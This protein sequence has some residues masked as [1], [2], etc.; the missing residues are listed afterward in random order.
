MAIEQVSSL[1]KE[2]MLTECCTHSR[3]ILDLLYYLICLNNPS[4]CVCALFFPFRLELLDMPFPI[5]N[6]PQEMLVLKS[7][8]VEFMQKVNI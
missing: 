2:H 4:S 6:R 7:N 1:H 8:K 5:S 3:H